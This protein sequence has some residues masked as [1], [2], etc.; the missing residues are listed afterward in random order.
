MAVNTSTPLSPLTPEGP[1]GLS[2]AQQHVPLPHH[3][4]C[5]RQAVGPV[6]FTLITSLKACLQ[7][8]S[9]F[10][11]LGVRA[12]TYEFWEPTIQLITTS[13]MEFWILAKALRMILH[14]LLTV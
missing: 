11:V 1:L 9:H 14:G 7:I 3:R 8:Q 5:Q 4:N 13:R 12:S 2:K 6:I 10:E